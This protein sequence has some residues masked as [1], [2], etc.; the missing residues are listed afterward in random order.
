MWAERAS[1]A[2]PLVGPPPALGPWLCLQAVENFEDVVFCRW[3]ARNNAKKAPRPAP[4]L[5]LQR[6]DGRTGADT[7]DMDM[8]AILHRKG[9]RVR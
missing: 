6:R 9:D 1:P 3:R 8:V 4:P 7:G 5:T 2:S